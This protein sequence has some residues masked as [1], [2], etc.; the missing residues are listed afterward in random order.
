MF[1]FV[2]FQKRTIRIKPLQATQQTDTRQQNRKIANLGEII[3][4]NLWRKFRYL[5]LA[6]VIFELSALC[7]DIEMNKLQLLYR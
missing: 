4:L 1:F 3:Y 5:Q 7:I 2:R 6:I